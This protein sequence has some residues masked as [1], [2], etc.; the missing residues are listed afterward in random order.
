MRPS[1]V[2]FHIPALIPESFVADVHH[3]LIEYKRIASAT[4]KQALR[5]LQ[6]DLIDRFGLLPE[7]L[8]TLFR[9]TQIKL[10]TV[11][12]GIEKIDIGEE[13]GKIVFNKNPNIDPMKIIQLIQSRPSEYRFDGKQTLRINCQS[14]ELESR[15]NQLEALLRKLAA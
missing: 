3:R 15:F 1:E 14:D 11:A 7:A 10:Q 4:D 13:H 9:I 8:K 12:L 2:D 6:M 5:E